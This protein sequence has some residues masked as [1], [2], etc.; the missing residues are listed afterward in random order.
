MALRP[1]DAHYRRNFFTQSEYVTFGRLAVNDFELAINV[2]VLLIYC[3]EVYLDFACWSILD[4]LIVLV[5][6]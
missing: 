6:F 5:Y 3:T 1:L 2:I 4:V